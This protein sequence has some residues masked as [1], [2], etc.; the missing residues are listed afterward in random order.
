MPRQGSAVALRRGK[1]SIRAGLPPC[2]K[3]STFLVD[4]G[5]DLTHGIAVFHQFVI[6]ADAEQ[7]GQHVRNAICMPRPLE[8]IV[9]G[10]CRTERER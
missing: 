6:D 9:D 5:H 8:S 7:T 2:P 1:S 10:Q 3:G 4:V